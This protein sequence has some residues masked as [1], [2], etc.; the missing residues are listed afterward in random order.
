M[1]AILDVDQSAAVLMTSPGRARSLGIPPSRWIYLLGAADAHDRWFVSERVNY[2]SSP[3]IRATGSAALAMAGV[4]IEQVQHLDLYSCFPCAVQIGRDMLGIADDDPRPLT[5]TGGLPYFG[6]PG[7]DYSMHAIATMVDRLRAAPGTVGLVS[8]LGWYLTKHAV[9][10]Y[11]TAPPS[12]PWRMPEAQTVQA[13]V[14]AEPSPEV[15]R[16]AEG[17]GTIETY[18]V[19]HDRESA[20]LAGIVVGR[21]ADGRRF[22]ATL[23]GDRAVLEALTVREGVGLAGTVRPHDG[24]NRF[25]PA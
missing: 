7:N 3:A 2:W 12:G 25:A 11:G 8:A 19:L 13:L 24:V 17:R 16:E 23:P 14:D 10:V 4:T 20:P 15:V 18:T 1:N 5:I 21:L 22:L 9:G 6:G